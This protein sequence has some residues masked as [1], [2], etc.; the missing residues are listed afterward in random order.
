MHDVPA[1][2]LGPRMD[3]LAWNPLG[4]ALIADFATL[5]PERRNMP[6]LVFLDDD[7]RRLYPDWETVARETVAYLRL[8]AGRAPD[9]ADLAELIGELSLASPD[10]ARWWADHDVREK[11]HGSK[12]MVHPEVGE[13]TLE[14][15]TLVLPDE[16]EQALVTYTAEPGS[17]SETAL[18]LLATL[19]AQT[20][21]TPRS[22]SH[23]RT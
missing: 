22:E 12:R 5:P 18:R 20:P 17:P 14:Y 3:V 19:A 21:S 8:A 16:P 10:F 4:A 23:S 9:D 11:T 2:V 1:F 13:M 6:R 7:A 15:E